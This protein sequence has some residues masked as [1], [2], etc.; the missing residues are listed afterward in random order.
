MPSNDRL[1]I[2]VA[3]IIPGRVFETG[4]GDAA[5]RHLI[6]PAGDLVV[7]LQR[8]QD[9]SLFVADKVERPHERAALLER[10]ARGIDPQQAAGDL[11]VRSPGHITAA[12]RPRP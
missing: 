2:P 9:R 10:A 8:L 12:S 1:R 7:A 6:L 11:E 4:T 3:I 5:K